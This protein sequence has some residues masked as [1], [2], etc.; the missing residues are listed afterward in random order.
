MINGG[1][2]RTIHDRPIRLRYQQYVPQRRSLMG[3]ASTGGRLPPVALEGQVVSSADRASRSGGSCRC[4]GCS[5]GSRRLRSAVSCRSR[6]G[7]TRELNALNHIPRTYRR[8]PAPIELTA[9]YV[10]RHRHFLSY[11]QGE[12]VHIIPEEL[13]AHLTWVLRTKGFEDIFLY[14]PRVSS[15]TGTSAQG[16][17]LDD[18]TD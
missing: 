10:D 3:L 9:L 4:C 17:D 2:L 11:L 1:R 6:S 16:E 13:E 8:V 12:L 15:L 18:F 14:L 5:S 7:Y